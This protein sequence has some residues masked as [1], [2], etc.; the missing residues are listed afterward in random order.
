MKGYDCDGVITKGVRPEKPDDVIITGRSFQE[1][2]ET[3]ALLRR[4]NI[5]NAVYFNPIPLDDC[6]PA[7]SGEW[8]A[9][10]INKLHI[11]V[12]YEDEELQANIIRKNCPN[13]TVEMV[14]L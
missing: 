4:L 14:A 2:V 13:V 10:M 8:K 1:S 7:L 11:D 9:T 6:H 5:F 12:F 3:Y